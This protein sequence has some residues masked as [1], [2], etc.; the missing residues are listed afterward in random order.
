MLFIIIFALVLIG[1]FIGQAYY[2]QHNAYAQGYTNGHNDAYRQ[3]YT[4]GYADGKQAGLSS[5][6]SQ[7]YASGKTAGYTQGKQDGAKDGY[8]Q[9]YIDGYKAGEQYELQSI[10][11]WLEQTCSQY[12]QPGYYLFKIITNPDGTLQYICIVS[13]Y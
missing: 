11:S 9:G 12:Y 2:V 8:S 13:A 4:V 1:A 6:Y 5:G 10:K 7:G 3:G